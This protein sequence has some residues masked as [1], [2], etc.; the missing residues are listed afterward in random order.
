[1]RD[2]IESRFVNARAFQAPTQQIDVA[3][4]T[5]A[6]LRALIDVNPNLAPL[7]ALIDVDPDRLLRTVWKTLMVTFIP[8]MLLC[9]LNFRSSVDAPHQPWF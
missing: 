3:L 4:R 6:P 2:N 1:M 9:Y 8:I 7:Q 5:L